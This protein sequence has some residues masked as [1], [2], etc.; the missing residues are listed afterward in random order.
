MVFRIG[1]TSR[2]LDDAVTAG[3]LSRA[4]LAAIES[5]G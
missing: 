3:R 2:D 4:M 1:L 5:D